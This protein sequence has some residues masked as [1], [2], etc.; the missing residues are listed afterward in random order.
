MKK[1]ANMNIYLLVLN[2]F[3]T[4]NISKFIEQLVT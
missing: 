1:S 2:L 3:D 4:R